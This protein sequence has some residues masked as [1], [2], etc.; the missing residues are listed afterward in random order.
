MWDSHNKV[1]KLGI[2][3]VFE[4]EG[5]ALD[6]TQASPLL[7]KHSAPSRTPSPALTLDSV[8]QRILSEIH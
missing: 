1:T 8:A 5:G 3:C 7:G 4:G 2:T 6:P